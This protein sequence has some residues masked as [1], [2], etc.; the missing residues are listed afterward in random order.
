MIIS[1]EEW[2]NFLETVCL[3]SIPGFLE[4][5]IEGRRMSEDGMTRWKSAD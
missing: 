4:D 2:E 3:M 1:E 5:I